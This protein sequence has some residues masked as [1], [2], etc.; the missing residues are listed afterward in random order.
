M[1]EMVINAPLYLYAFL[2]NLF[3][4]YPLTFTTGF[5][6]GTITFHNG[7]TTIGFSKESKLWYMSQY[8]KRI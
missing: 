6:K 4:T 3:V 2:K 5:H 8:H 7:T 1:R